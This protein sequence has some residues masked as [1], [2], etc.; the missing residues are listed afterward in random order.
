M[1]EEQ[2]LK[3][4]PIQENVGIVKVLNPLSQED[5]LS[6]VSVTQ[7]KKLKGVLLDT[8]GLRDLN[9]AIMGSFLVIY[10]KLTDDQIAVGIADKD[11]ENR[12]LMFVCRI[13]D[14]I[15]V[16]E[17]VEKGITQLKQGIMEEDKWGNNGLE[18]D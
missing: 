10:D 7:E 11:P 5:V 8:N 3:N 13:I 1:S 17:T 18:E 15:P 16:F 2:K 6:I 12:E 9:S 4:F 14:F